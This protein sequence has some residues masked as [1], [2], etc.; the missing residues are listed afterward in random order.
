MEKLL[1]I[2]PLSIILKNSM[3]SLNKIE[4][5]NLFMCM[6]VFQMWQFC[7]MINREN[8]WYYLNLTHGSLLI[9]LLIYKLHAN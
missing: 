9:Q 1:Q 5:A 2:N 4:D 7:F 6:Y 8:L 3:I